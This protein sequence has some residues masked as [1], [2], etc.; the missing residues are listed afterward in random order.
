MKIKDRDKRIEFLNNTHLKKGQKFKL[1]GVEPSWDDMGITQQDWNWNNGFRDLDTEKYEGSNP[2]VVRH[3]KLTD[4]KMEEIIWTVPNDMTYSQLLDDWVECDWMDSP[5]YYR[6]G[7]LVE[8]E[9]LFSFDESN[10]FNKQ[11]EELWSKWL[12]NKLNEEEE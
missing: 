1:V 12:N 2:C 4:N 9:F 6:F 10:G 5:L 11:I 7:L 3:G 8:K